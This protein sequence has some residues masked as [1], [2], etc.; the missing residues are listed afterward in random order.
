MPANSD[1]FGAEFR[2]PAVIMQGWLPPE[3]RCPMQYTKIA[4]GLASALSDPSAGDDEEYLVS[5]RTAR[6]LTPTEQ[7]EF[8][9]LG[10]VGVDSK[11]PVLS[12]K[13]P[14]GKISELSEKPWVRLLTLSRRLT[15]S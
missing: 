12:A 2:W 10:G 15:P 1:R 5:V 14:R 13:L 11:L 9:Q 4:A 7:S 8:R 3:R 6:P